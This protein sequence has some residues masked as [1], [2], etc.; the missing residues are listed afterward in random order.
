MTIHSHSNQVLLDTLT[1]KTDR[2]VGT[3]TAPGVGGNMNVTGVGFQPTLL[4]IIMLHPN[5]ATRTIRG[6]G[7]TDGI[8]QFC[9][10]TDTTETASST[11]KIIDW[12]DTTTITIQSASF[13]SFNTDGFTLNFT[14]STFNTH[15]FGYV[16]FK[17]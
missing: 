8:T 14:T 12:I 1:F 13:V 6:E 3:F 11:S 2:K 16:A 17:I 5:N 9:N 15:V 10:Y 7:W 4:Y